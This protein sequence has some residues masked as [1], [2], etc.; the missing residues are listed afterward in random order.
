MTIN[1]IEAPIASAFCAV[2][3]LAIPTGARKT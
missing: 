1:P 3:G 2:G